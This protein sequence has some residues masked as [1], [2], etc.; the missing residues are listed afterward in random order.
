M[1]ARLRGNQSASKQLQEFNV[2]DHC[3]R[4]QDFCDKQR[5]SDQISD[6]RLVRCVHDA[7]VGNSSSMQSEEVG[8]VRENNSA[9]GLCAR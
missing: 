6:R 5:A 8:I 9:I 4:I 2:I 7:G 3:N 1:S